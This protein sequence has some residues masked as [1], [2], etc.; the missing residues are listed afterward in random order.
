MATIIFQAI[1]DISRK[2]RGMAKFQN[3]LN[4]IQVFNKKFNIGSTFT[5]CYAKFAKN[6]IH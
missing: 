4:T 6:D 2:N 5:K 1:N 3:C